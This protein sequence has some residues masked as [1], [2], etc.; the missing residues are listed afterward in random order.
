MGSKR[1]IC[2]LNFAHLSLRDI[3][4][5]TGSW[6]CNT[7]GTFPRKGVVALLLFWGH[8]IVAWFFRPISKCLMH[9]TWDQL[10][11]RERYPD[12]VHMFELNFCKYSLTN[13]QNNWRHSHTYCFLCKWFKF[14]C[15]KSQTHCSRWVKG[16]ASSPKFLQSVKSHESSIPIALPS[17]HAPRLVAKECR[18]ELS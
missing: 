6:W 17:P 1:N 15:E 10:L 13:A 4:R 5:K 2:C 7:T 9:R 16:V 3:L 8:T 11:R 12:T 18:V 14:A